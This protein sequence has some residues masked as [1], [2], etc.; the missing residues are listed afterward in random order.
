[1]DW[2]QT[3]RVLLIWPENTH[4]LT[5]QL[6]LVMLERHCTAMGSQ[7][8]L[9]TSHPDVQYHA[10]K[11]GIPTF[12]TKQ[13][14]QSQPW[15]R[16]DRFYRRSRIQEQLLSPR[17]VDLSARPPS[18]ALP[19]IDLPYWGKLTVFTAAVFAVLAIATLFLPRS[20]ITFPTQRQWSEITLPVQASPQIEDVHISGAVPVSEITINLEKRGQRAASGSLA[21]PDAH[22]S[23]KVIFKNL[24]AHEISLPENTVLTTS[25][26]NGIKYKTTQ[27]VVVPA[28][29]G[30]QVQAA[31][32]ALE[33]G[34]V[35]NQPA[36]IINGISAPAG[37]DLTVHNPEPIRG[38]SDVQVTQPTERDRRIL[39]QQVK[40][41][42]KTLAQA[43]I[44]E[45]L[46]EGDILLSQSPR[47]KDVKLEEYNPPEG[48]PGETLELVLRA[49]Y[50]AWV[51]KHDDLMD[52]AREV[53]QARRDAEHFRPLPESI[54]LVHENKPAVTQEGE[55]RWEMTVR[56]RQE[57]VIDKNIILQKVL[58]QPPHKAQEELAREYD[59]DPPPEI[60]LR[61]RWWPWMPYLPFRIEVN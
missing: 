30:E 48:E 18:R 25:R 37:A 29:I 55:A 17:E 6:D 11:T 35:G 22:A 60:N 49:Q 56:W 27:E 43:G 59:L 28:G 41:G 10:R 45:S 44:Q 26:S 14:A 16:S 23:G 50:A 4:V 51:I 1:M 13:K 20:Q 39:A 9:V 21:L 47:L 58:G 61:P 38:G 57:P 40:E 2:S 33:P 15:F 53:V 42:L 54:N 46:E 19:E 31:V 8:A 12:K 34:T 3:P 36:G 7:L 32:L 5:D 52:L 24:T